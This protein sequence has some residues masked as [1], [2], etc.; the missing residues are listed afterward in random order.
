LMAFLF[1]A[2]VLVMALLVTDPNPA[3]AEI[4]LNDLAQSIK[5]GQIRSVIIR[6]SG[7]E[8]WTNDD[9]VVQFHV[10]GRT[11]V[12]HTLAAYGVT[13][14]ELRKTE[15]KVAEPSASEVWLARIGVW[16]PTSIMGL[17]LVLLMRQSQPRAIMQLRHRPARSFASSSARRTCFADVAGVDEARSELVEV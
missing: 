10:D 3:R 7:G 13:A 1:L 17:A 2:P 11:D 14:A 16:L 8:A 4:G 15:I 5:A 12:L 9:A 6:A